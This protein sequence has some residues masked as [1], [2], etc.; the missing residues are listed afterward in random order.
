MNNLHTTS[1]ISPGYVPVFT[2]SGLYPGKVSR[3]VMI[4]KLKPISTPALSGVKAWWD[5]GVMVAQGYDDGRVVVAGV[6]G[7]DVDENEEVDIGVNESIWN[8]YITAVAKRVDAKRE[9]KCEKWNLERLAK[10]EFYLLLQFLVLRL[11]TFLI[12]RVHRGLLPPHFTQNLPP[13][14]QAYPTPNPNPRHKPNDLSRSYPTYPHPLYR[15][16]PDT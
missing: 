3:E 16:G 8:S 7:K 10:C 15:N 11:L 2:E 6:S 5:D 14:L 9:P 1:T 13:L 4:M 12:T